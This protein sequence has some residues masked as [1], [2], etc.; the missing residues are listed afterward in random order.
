[1]CVLAT[2]GMHFCSLRLPHKSRGGRR[3]DDELALVGIVNLFERKSPASRL[4][5]RDAA[6]SN[7]V[8]EDDPVAVARQLAQAQERLL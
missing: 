5:D 1:M 4:V 2:T 7:G 8:I 6:S 3:V